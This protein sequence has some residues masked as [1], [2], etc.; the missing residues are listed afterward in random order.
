M[1]TRNFDP[2]ADEEVRVAHVMRGYRG[3][4]LTQ[5]E[6][7]VFMAFLERAYAVYMRNLEAKID[8]AG[9]QGLWSAGSPRTRSGTRTSSATW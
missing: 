5:I 1:V 3:D 9:A 7:L 6:T 8:R 2:T 4:K